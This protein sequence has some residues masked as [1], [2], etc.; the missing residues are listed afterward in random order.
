M[1]PT[2]VRFIITEAMVE[3]FAGLRLTTF[4]TVAVATA[5][6]SNPRC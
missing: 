1:E 4:C 6:P 2:R 3:A 5:T